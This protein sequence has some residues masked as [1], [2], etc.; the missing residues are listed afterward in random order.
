[1]KKQ[2]I[3]FINGINSFE[4]N[5]LK[6]DGK[7]AESAN[8]LPTNNDGYYE[9]IIYDKTVSGRDFRYLLVCMVGINYAYFMNFATLKSNFGSIP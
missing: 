4:T 5:N 9:Y 1:M 7:K 3:K 2:Q 6:C 8:S